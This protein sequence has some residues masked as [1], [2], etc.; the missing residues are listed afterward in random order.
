MIDMYAWKGSAGL[1]PTDRPVI[2]WG[3]VGGWGG[4]VGG[5]G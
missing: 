1:E 4:W 2:T 5:G 3:W